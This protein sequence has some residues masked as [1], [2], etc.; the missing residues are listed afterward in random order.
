[1]AVRATLAEALRVAGENRRAIAEYERL[2]EV[3]PRSP[4]AL[5]NLAWLYYLENDPRALA[6]ARRAWELAA[7]NPN[8]LDTYGWLLVES[9]AVD[10][11]VALL[12]TADGMGGIV[13]PDIRYHYAA[14]L[15]RKG[16]TRRARELLQALLKEAEDFPNH[17]EAAVL[18][19][20]LEQGS[21]T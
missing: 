6:T 11:G 21:A 13:Q 20:S 2:L 8:V 19:K 3:A 10:E 14:A 16:D 9:G 5:N 15:S 17:A 7:K 1:M 12:V 4:P 18:L